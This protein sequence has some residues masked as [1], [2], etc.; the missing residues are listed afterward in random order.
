LTISRIG[1]ALA[2]TI[3]A[4]T[5]T[6]AGMTV[7]TLWLSSGDV[8]SGAV[9]PQ[10]NLPQV[11]RESKRDR[12]IARADAPQTA[13]Y[14]LA[15]AAS[16]DMVETPPS[17][18]E[19]ATPAAQMPAPVVAATV[20]VAKPKPAVP[21]LPSASMLRDQQIASIKERLKLS[22]A[23][24]RHWPAVEVALRGVLR[25]AY[26]AKRTGD[27]SIDPNSPEV[28]RLKSA[29]MPLLMQMRDDQK[30]EVRQLAHVIGLADVAAML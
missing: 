24:E 27:G 23:Q 15:S 5:V 21:K 14:Q 2:S 20:P 18:V 13:T 1:L 12:L 10:G 6:G 19:A 17:A 29:A 9:E 7:G 3:V 8:L 28:Q 16:T 11:N 25:H 4:A 22:S 26:E 30:R